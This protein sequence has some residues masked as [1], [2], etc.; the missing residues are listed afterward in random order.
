MLADHYRGTPERT[1]QGPVRLHG[2]RR[3][4]T[5]AG[6]LHPLGKAKQDFLG[7]FYRTP[8]IE[9]DYGKSELVPQPH[10]GED[11]HEPE[12]DY[13]YE[14]EDYRSGH[15]VHDY[16]FEP[17]DDNLKNVVLICYRIQVN[18]ILLIQN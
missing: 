14:P 10:Y 2:L 11:K 13:G 6:L 15:S 16:G 4:N 18:Q 12:P 8:K 7:N 17:V 3:R 1:H 9:F 5:P